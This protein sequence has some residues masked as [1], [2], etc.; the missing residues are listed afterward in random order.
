[1]APS[2]QTLF[3]THAW[4]TF[5]L[6]GLVIFLFGLLVG[7]CLWRSFRVQADR[8]ESLNESLRERRRV[9]KSHNREFSEFMKE[10]SDD[11]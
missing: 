1:M 7:W 3:Y 2:I 4:E 11:S 6:G 5:F 10:L 9:I 8:V